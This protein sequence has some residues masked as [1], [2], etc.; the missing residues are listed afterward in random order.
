[1]SHAFNSDSWAKT[2]CYIIRNDNNARLT[3]QFNPEQIPYSRGAKYT[4]VESPGMSYPLTQYAGGEAREFAFDVFYYD[5]PYTG[6]IKSAR[7]F[8]EGLL[9]PE[10]NTMGFIKP[11]SFTLAYG[12]F[13]KKL[14][15]KNLS[16][17]DEWMN[18]DGNPIMTRF[19]LSVRQI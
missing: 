18:E 19:T 17:K 4:S 8:L 12:Y 9:P 11:P 15:L 14:V 10:E 1:M 2:R 3:F 16:V 5:R 6:K 13:V 7:E